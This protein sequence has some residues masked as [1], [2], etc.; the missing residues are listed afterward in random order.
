MTIAKVAGGVSK[1]AQ[2]PLEGPDVAVVLDTVRA[3]VHVHGLVQVGDLAEHHHQIRA[4]VVGCGKLSGAVAP[5]GARM[6][7]P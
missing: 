6:S 3:A 1:H 5:S 2:Q 4:G 7:K